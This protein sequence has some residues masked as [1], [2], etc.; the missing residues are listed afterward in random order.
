MGTVFSGANLLLLS[1]REGKWPNIHGLNWG[2]FTLL[3]EVITVITPFTTGFWARLVLFPAD[4]TATPT[5]VL[6]NERKL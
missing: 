3:I 4:A 1:F 2:Y 5:R 6:L